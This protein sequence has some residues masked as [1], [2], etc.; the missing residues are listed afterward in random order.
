MKCALR[1]SVEKSGLPHKAVAEALG[2]R[3]SYLSDAL[4]EYHA[5][6]FQARWLVPFMQV[7][8]SLEPLRWMATQ[9]GCAVVELPHVDVAGDAVYAEAMRVVEELGEATQTLKRS[10][11]DS[12]VDGAERLDI[13]RQFADVVEAAL[14]AQSIVR[15][16]LATLPSVKPAPA[17]MTLPAPAAKAVSA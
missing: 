1:S 8:H 12:V 9:L 13:E 15:T 14:R 10:L 3:P 6:Q 5:T 16:Q 17:R 11:A 4:N 2:M 7:T